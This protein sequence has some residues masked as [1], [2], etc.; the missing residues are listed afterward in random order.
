MTISIRLYELMPP[1]KTSFRSLCNRNCFKTKIKGGRTGYLYNSKKRWSKNKKER[2]K[3]PQ[4]FT[5]TQFKNKQKPI[6]VKGL[7]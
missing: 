3:R 7:P 1:V 2:K 6:N 4:T 5:L